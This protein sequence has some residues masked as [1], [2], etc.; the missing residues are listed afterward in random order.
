MGK[1][2]GTNTGYM[3]LAFV[4]LNMQVCRLTNGD[5]KSLASFL[6]PGSWAIP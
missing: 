1:Q 4:P 3:I 2:K 6:V 5:V